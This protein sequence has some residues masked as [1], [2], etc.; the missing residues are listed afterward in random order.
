MRTS[1]HRLTIV[2]VAVALAA[3]CTVTKVE[4]EDADAERD[5]APEAAAEAGFPDAVTQGLTDDTIRIGAALI[6]AAELQAQG[7]DIE[8]IDPQ[9]LLQAWIDTANETG[10]L[11]GRQVEMVF[12]PYL[13]ISDTEAETA[14]TALTEDEEVFAVIGQFSGDT[15]LCITETHALPYIGMYGLSPERQTRSKGPFFAVEMADDRQREASI[16]AMVE[17]GELEGNVGLYYQAKDQAIVDDVVKP[18]LDEAGIEPVVETVLDDVGGG[19]AGGTDQAAVDQAIDTI[20]ERHRSADVDV[21]LNV[22]NFADPMGGFQRKGW[23]PERI[24]VTTQQA[25]SED[26]IAETEIDPAILAQTLVVAPYVPSKDELLADETVTTCID[27]YNATDPEAPIDP[28]TATRTELAGLANLCTA[29]TMFRRGVDDAGDE[30]TAQTWADAVAGIG[31][32]HL[33]GIPF[34]SL[35]DGKQS[36]GD[37]IGAYVFDPDAGSFVLEGDPIEADA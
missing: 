31:D 14:C 26:V 4:G 23:T 8:A 33:P 13:P 29:W 35:G 21:F 3:G 6:N 18:A 32:D 9:A 10:G 11:G 15:S 1:I 2:L 28:D 30:L 20:V 24:L 12:Q 25:L 16:A 19:A 36:A 5:S 37:T 34:S 27:E 22:S 7:I 17:R